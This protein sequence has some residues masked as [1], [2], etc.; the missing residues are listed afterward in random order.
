MKLPIIL[1]NFKCYEQGTGEKALK[2][3]KLCQFISKEYGINISISPQFVDIKAITEEVEIPVFSQHIDPIEP[4]SHTGHVLPLSVK[5]AD[6]IGTLIN[7]SERKLPLD[8][9]KKRI[10]VAKKYNLISVCCSGNLEKSKSIVGFSPDFIAY[11]DPI[12]IGS[13]RPISK[14]KPEVVQEFVKIVKNISPNVIPLCGAGIST[15]EDVRIALELGCK[16]VLLASAVV[17]ALDP[18]SVLVDIAEAIK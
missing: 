2:L 4:G 11:E 5:D 12:L 16:G 10:E 17:K 7:H 13:G 18:E 14:E 15:G 8:E 6:V 3:A 1:V 9:I